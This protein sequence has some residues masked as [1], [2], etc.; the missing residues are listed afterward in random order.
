MR[1]VDGGEKTKSGKLYNTRK[2]VLVI[3]VLGVGNMLRDLADEVNGIG[4]HE[5]KVRRREVKLTLY[6]LRHCPI[7]V[8]WRE[9][10]VTKAQDEIAYMMMKL[11]LWEG[12]TS[13]KRRN[14]FCYKSCY[15]NPSFPRH[16]HF[17]PPAQKGA[18]PPERSWKAVAPRLHMSDAGEACFWS[19]TWK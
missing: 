10:Q 14:S 3:V 1:M 8:A 2:E 17:V 9:T 19:I 15:P 6:R 16:Y 12:R 7:L 4:R 13:P 11:W 18:T 5:L